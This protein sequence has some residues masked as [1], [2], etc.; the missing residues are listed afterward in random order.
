MTACC[1]EHTLSRQATQDPHLSLFRQQNYRYRAGPWV[2]TRRAR[3]RYP[4]QAADLSSIFKMTL[5]ANR[6]IAALV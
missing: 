1:P 2:S 5:T 3:V 6:L 4:L